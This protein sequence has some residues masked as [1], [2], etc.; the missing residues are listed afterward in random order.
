MSEGIFGQDVTETEVTAIVGPDR[1][2]QQIERLAASGVTPEVLEQYMALWERAD[3]R[4]AK[5][6]FASAMVEVQRQVPTVVRDAQNNHTNSRYAKLETVSRALKPIM[7]SNGFSL[8]FSEGERPRD[9]W[10]RVVAVLSHDGGHSE[11]Y[12][13]DG[14]MDNLGPNGKPCKTELH[15][16]Q[17][18]FSY[19]E[20]QLRCSIFGITVAD[21]DDDGNQGRAEPITE[22]QRIKLVEMFEGFENPAERKA[23]FLKGFELGGFDEIPAAKYDTLVAAVKKRLSEGKK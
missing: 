1:V 16:M 15:G 21:Q 14:P 12:H 4:R 3:T 18:A 22:E 10:V 9:G 7:L 23:A 17:S 5:E 19:L 6:E 2:A 8:T 11:T 20:R 13:R